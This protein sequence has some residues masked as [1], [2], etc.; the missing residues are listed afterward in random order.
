MNG[1]TE[2]RWRKRAGERIERMHAL[3]WDEEVG[4][5]LDYDL[6]NGRRGEVPALTGLQ[7]MAHGVAT[8]EQARRMVANLPLFER[9][10]GL[11]YTAETPD[12]RRYQWAYPISWVPLTCMTVEGLA[13]HGFEE[14]A[15]RI[16]HTFVRTTVRLFEKTGKLWEKIDAET[17]EPAQ[18]EYA[19]A[20][21]F[22]WTAGL[23]ILFTEDREGHPR[24]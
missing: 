15:Q 2:T 24:K 14:E 3:L 22:D 8:P 11:A 19:S 7:T 16:A 6:A 4:L 20:P 9:E 5:F 17:G 23:F 18:A 13:H 10:H 12:C 1:E 21:L